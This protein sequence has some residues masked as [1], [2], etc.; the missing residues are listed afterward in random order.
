[1]PLSTPRSVLLLSKR[2]NH[3]DRLSKVEFKG[4]KIRL[5][6]WPCDAF[7]TPLTCSW[8][9]DTW[10]VSTTTSC[11]CFLRTRPD[12]KVQETNWKHEA[13]KNCDSFA[14]SRTYRVK[15]FVDSR[16][17]C[18]QGTSYVNNNRYPCQVK[19]TAGG[20]NDNTFGGIRFFKDT[21]R[22]KWLVK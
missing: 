15:P 5:S 12:L 21:T 3:G 20:R 6:N 14:N 13:K 16:T 18:L 22:F 1:V 19:W 9:C 8:N 2:W 11:L 4:G 10:D 17:R 7:Q